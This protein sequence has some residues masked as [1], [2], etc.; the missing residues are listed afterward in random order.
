MIIVTIIVS[1][2]GVWACKT[3]AASIKETRKE[4][5]EKT[6]WFVYVLYGLIAAFLS[7]SAGWI[8]RIV[9]LAILIGITILAALNQEG[10]ARF[11]SNNFLALAIW[12]CLLMSN[13]SALG[14]GHKSW[15]G[16]VLVLAILIPIVAGWIRLLA[17]EGVLKLPGKM[18]QE[19]FTSLAM[20]LSVIAVLTIAIIAVVLI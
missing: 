1:F 6:S 4:N 16:L 9:Y 18:S 20:R 17:L 2:L 19:D 5:G 7:V 3:A 10:K 15:H 12:F 8:P 11:W 13:A 14:H